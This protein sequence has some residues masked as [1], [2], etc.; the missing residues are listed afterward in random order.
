MVALDRREQILSCATRLFESKPYDEVSMTDIAAA[1][2]VAR[3]LVH[4][5]FGTKREVF[6]AAVHRVADLPPLALAELSASTL[7]E[8][9]ETI[10]DHF[11]TAI[12]RHQP[13]WTAMLTMTTSG[14]DDVRAILRQ[15]DETTADALA[16]L[17]GFQLEGAPLATYHGASAAFGSFAR[18]VAREWVVEGRLQRE[19]C[20]RLLVATLSAAIDQLATTAS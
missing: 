15:S 16:Q 11:L 9:V 1:A 5:Y 6:L 3:P 20:Y 7:S 17:L 2:G 18:E 13:L 10:V 4:H 19:D 12:S 8:S 14:G